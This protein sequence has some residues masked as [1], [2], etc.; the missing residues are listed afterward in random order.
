LT[1]LLAPGIALYL[2]AVEPGIIRRPRLVATCAVALVGT[3]VALYLELPIRAAMGAPLVYGH[4]DTL[5]GFM[6]V[7]LGQQFGGL[8][9]NP[10]DDLGQKAAD[11]ATLAGQQLGVL[12][13]FVPA[14]A[15]VVA[16]RQPRYALLTM[17]W[18]VVTCWFA[19]SFHDGVV[20]RYYL[21]P[22]LIAITWLGVAA[23]LLVE[24]AFPA[25]AP[26]DLADEGAAGA[27]AAPLART[28]LVA[29]IASLALAAGL[30]L[31]AALAAPAT[32]RR[33]DL[34][35]DA[36]ATDW[37]R[38]VM[39]VAEER[40]VIVSWWSFSTPLWYRTLVMGE[41][42]DVWVVADRDR[43]DENLGSIDDV[44]RA[45][46]ASRPVYLIRYPNE[47]SELE[48]T[49]ELELVSDPNGMQPLY[50]VVGPRAGADQTAPAARSAIVQPP[51]ATM[52]P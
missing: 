26:R 43:L 48:A 23:G 5:G 7:V 11:L 42:P 21:G 27:A 38:W 47:I 17:T 46:L 40:A 52:R 35:R 6:Y 30:V 2:L 9:T 18:M 25:A 36:R 3:A 39:A 13:A 32:F 44:I 31:P 28:R 51:P 29:V 10:L 22:L 1:A 24:A 34:S 12:A 50:R 8:M 4:P 19:A 33:V 45:N 16:L 49:W 20:D 41:R 37:S 15:V 14:A